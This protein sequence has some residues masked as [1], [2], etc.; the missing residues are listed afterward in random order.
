[1]CHRD[2]Q[3]GFECEDICE[4]KRSQIRPI[5]HGV[6]G[7]IIC[8]ESTGVWFR[9]FLEGVYTLHGVRFTELLSNARE[10]GEDKFNTCT[11]YML[12]IS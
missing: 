4:L 1:M 9:M 12:G 7:G 6:D 2:W 3:R 10:L 5:Q 8:C 11:S